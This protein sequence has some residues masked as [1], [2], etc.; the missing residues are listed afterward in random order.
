MT[1]NIHPKCEH[2][3]GHPCHGCTHFALCPRLHEDTERPTNI[4]IGAIDYPVTYKRDLHNDGRRLDGHIT[5]CPYSIQLD[6]DLGHQGTQTVLWHEIIHGI[7][8]HAGRPP[9]DNEIVE[10][11]AYGIVQVLRDNPELARLSKETHDSS[12][13]DG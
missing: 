7:V 9:M 3:T 10:M 11:L 12:N 6:E 5:Y 8:V 2:L 4:R 1:N 13:K